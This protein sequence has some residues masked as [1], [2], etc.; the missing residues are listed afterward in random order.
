MKLDR[1][2][3]NF[4]T[5]G[6][7]TALVILT[8]QIGIPTAW[9]NRFVWWIWLYF[10]ILSYG[11]HLIFANGINKSDWDRHNFFLAGISVKL[12]LSSGVVFS[13]FWLVKANAVSFLVN[14]FILYF[15]YTFFEIKTLL[16][17]L[18]THSKSESN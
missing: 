17:S 15:V 13:Y 8:L 4:L 14:F 9:L 12:F 7:V 3:Q 16:L 18:H 6:L 10:N 5:I 11:T 1:Y 2:H